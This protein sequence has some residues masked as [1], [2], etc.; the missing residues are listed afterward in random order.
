M[1]PSSF[2]ARFIGGKKNTLEKYFFLMF[3]QCSKFNFTALLS[4]SQRFRCNGT[5]NKICTLRRET[6]MPDNPNQYIVLQI[7]E[8]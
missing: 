7:V 6:E 5:K 2:K 1:T 3:G 4:W 8:V